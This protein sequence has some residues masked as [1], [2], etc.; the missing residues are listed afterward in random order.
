[1]IRTPFSLSCFP[2]QFP[3]FYMRYNLG[4]KKPDELFFPWR[5]TIKSV[6]STSHEIITFS[7]DIYFFSQ[8]MGGQL[9]YFGLWLD[10]N[11]GSGHSR[12]QPSCTTYGS[13]QLSSEEEFKIDRL[14]AWGVGVPPENL[15]SLCRLS[16][17]S[18]SS[19]YNFI[20][21]QMCGRFCSYLVAK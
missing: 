12:G 8:G 10:E 6:K 11:F 7:A 4:H 19:N 17:D 20:M 18:D 1:M 3:P 14:E 5:L 9:N 13:P 2:S 21:C 15:V 16:L